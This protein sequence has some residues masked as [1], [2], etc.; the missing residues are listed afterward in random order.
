MNKMANK[1]LLSGDKVM[2]ELRKR[3]ESQKTRISL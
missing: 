2:P 3:Y 1:F